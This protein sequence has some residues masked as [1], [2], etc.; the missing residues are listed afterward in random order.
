M[1]VNNTSLNTVLMKGPDLLK[2][3]VGVLV[4]FREK[5]VAICGDIKEMFHQVRII[6]EDQVAQKFLWRG[7]ETNRPVETFIMRV[8]TFGASCSPS[9]A[10]Y[11]KNK[12]A[13]RFYQSQKN[14][15]KAIIDNTFVDDWL[16]S[17]NTEGELLDLAEKV[18]MIHHEGGFEMRNWLSNSKSVLQSLSAQP[19][20][21]EKFFEEPDCQYE[22][23]LGMW[24]IP[25]ADVLTFSQHFDDQLFDM[26]KV[27]TKRQI[28]RTTMKIFDPLGILGFYIV[29][30]KMILQDIWRSKVGWDDPI[31]SDEHDKWKAWLKCLPSISQVR[32]PRCYP[33]ANCSQ[34]LQLH[35]FVDASATAYAAVAYLRAEYGGKIQCSLLASKTRVSPLK[36]ISIPRLELMAAILGLRL[37]KFVSEELS[38]KI[39]SRTFWSDSKNVLF[40]INS[41]ARKYQHFV[42]YRIGEILEESKIS[43]WRWVPTRENVADEGTKWLKT[44]NFESNSRWFCGP[45]FLY[46]DETLWPKTDLYK[47]DSGIEILHHVE[48]KRKLEFSFK[49][50]CVDVQSFSQWEK[51][52]SS[53]WFVL[54]FLKQTFKKSANSD[55]FKMM[56]NLNSVIDA[57]IFLF[58]ACQE[59]FADEIAA[60]KSDNGNVH[61]KSP[62]YKL[63][64]Y[65]DEYGVIRMNGRIDAANNISYD[66]KRPIILPRHHSI[67]SLIIDFYHR[68][69][70]HHLNE[71]VV[72][73]MR[74]KFFI[75]GLRSL[76]R[77]TAR[78]C[79]RC[80][81]HRAAPIA[82]EMG[83]LPFE[84]TTSFTRPFSFTGVDYF[85][86]IEVEVGRRRE[87]RWG[88][89]FTCLTLRAVHLELASSLS[90]DCFLLILKQFI[91][92]R[93]TPIRI[94]SDNATNFR[95]ASRILMNEIENIATEEIERKHPQIEWAFIPPGSPHMGGA[96]ERLVRS[97][98]S[99]L[100]DIVPKTSIRED[101]LRAAFA[102]IE[103]ILNSRPLTYVP[104]E[105]PDCE[106]L[107]PNHFILGTSNGI[108]EKSSESVDGDGLRKNF[109]LASQIADQFWRRWIREY[110]PPDDLNGLKNH[111]NRLLLVTWC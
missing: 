44:P 66:M 88:V 73:E 18:R 83:L 72:N 16:Q 32:L 38:L 20:S 61:R 75:Y 19:S 37:S 47:N 27:P 111:K 95:G 36:P 104:L 4:R 52:R 41:D 79:Q 22:K 91:A 51:L 31:K 89:L 8:M 15:V 67:T 13:E 99:I 85:G 97:V 9:L 108:R 78:K 62:I 7:G 14:A 43:E 94:W 63:S 39:S 5:P 92:R 55:I 87:K 82:P 54:K 65:L 110:L 17:C 69:F 24:W 35:V 2:S 80:Q 57:E 26:S 25:Q 100:M 29:Y 48:M 42:A 98:K 109:K 90:T 23:V 34:N 21:Q 64:P 3:L 70:H 86:P 74:Q 103:F 77:S 10:N 33:L 45:Q 50:V 101:V 6:E 49:E 68:K 58:R 105:S 71:V 106:A 93:G 76:V 53:Q 28:L 46:E 60:L 56:E 84:R 102:D 12:N 11:V 1:T 59:E 96:W 30:A 40:W 107:T 81:N